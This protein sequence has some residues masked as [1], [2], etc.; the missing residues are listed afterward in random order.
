MK[1]IKIFI[2]KLPVFDGEIFNIF[3]MNIQRHRAHYAHDMRIRKNITIME[4]T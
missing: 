1:N 3:K 4:L 2:K